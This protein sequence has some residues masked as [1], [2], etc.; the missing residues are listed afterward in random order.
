MTRRVAVRSVASWC[1]RNGQ[2]LCRLAVRLYREDDGQDLI[3][4]VLL[5]GIIAVAAILI[6]PA[7]QSA[8]VSTYRNWNADTQAIWEPPP[9][10]GTP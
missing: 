9:P 3:E 1:R 2:R 10:T 8:M 7:M 6:F 5:T 4:Y